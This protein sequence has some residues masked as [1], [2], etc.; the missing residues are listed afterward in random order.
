MDGNLKKSKC[1]CEECISL[2]ICVNRYRI[3]CEIL[4][5]FL[6]RT[7]KNYSGKL[8]YGDRNQTNIKLTEKVFNKSFHGSNINSMST[9]WGPTTNITIDGDDQFVKKYEEYHQRKYNE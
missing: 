8:I 4:Y 9:S 3:K 7:R 2:A 5:H 1:P 6:C